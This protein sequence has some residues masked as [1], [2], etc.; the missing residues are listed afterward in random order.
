[1]ED[2]AAKRVRGGA[3]TVNRFVLTTADTYWI[4][5]DRNEYP[6]DT[7]VTEG[8]A[9]ATRDWLDGDTHASYKMMVSRYQ[10]LIGSAQR[11]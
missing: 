11:E 10:A 4:E 9:A 7:M 5:S 6:D 8:W 3:T 1:M 2:F